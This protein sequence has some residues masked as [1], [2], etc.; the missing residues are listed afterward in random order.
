M[1]KI[2][3]NTIRCR[4]VRHQRFLYLLNVNDLFTVQEKYEY[5]IVPLRCGKYARNQNKYNTVSYRTTSAILAIFGICY[6]TYRTG[7]VFFAVRCEQISTG[8]V[9][10]IIIIITILRVKHSR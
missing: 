3:I 5:F 9:F 4:F 1:L 7:T 8:E 2:K 10:N 6:S